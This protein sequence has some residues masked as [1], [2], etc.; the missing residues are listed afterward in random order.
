VPGQ[1]L[2][3]IIRSCPLVQ[4]KNPS[5]G[6]AILK[7]NDHIGTYR[8]VLKK[9]AVIAHSETLVTGR[10]NRHD[11][12]R[13]SLKREIWSAVDNSGWKRIVVVGFKGHID[14]HMSRSSNHP[15]SIV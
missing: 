10:P 15:N 6:D 1:N 8:H 9:A 3:P 4:K 11:D 13:Q 14:R 2:G 7:K 12:V 5:A